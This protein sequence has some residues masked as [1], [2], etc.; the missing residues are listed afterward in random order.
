M[1]KGRDKGGCDVCWLTCVVPPPLLQLTLHSPPSVP[2]PLLDPPSVAEQ[3]SW[4][5]VLNK[6]GWA[7]SLP[8]PLPS[9]SLLDQPAVLTLPRNHSFVAGRLG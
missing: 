5:E 6:E 3:G 7:I 4:V 1:G 2:T 8:L 9:L